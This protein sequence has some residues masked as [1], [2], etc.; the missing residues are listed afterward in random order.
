MG[1]PTHRRVAAQHSQLSATA[2]ST[3]FSELT[4]DLYH[5]C[6]KSASTTASHVSLLAC[7]GPGSLG[8]PISASLPVGP[9]RARLSQICLDGGLSD[10]GLRCCG[11]S[12]AKAQ[13]LIHDT[14]IHL[15]HGAAVQGLSGGLD[16]EL[17]RE[18]QTLK[19]A[20]RCRA[21]RRTRAVPGSAQASPCLPITRA[22]G[23]LPLPQ[24]GSSAASS[25]APD[26]LQQFDS[27]PPAPCNRHAATPHPCVA[28]PR[29]RT[30]RIRCHC[31][32]QCQSS[33]RACCGLQNGQPGLLL[34]KQRRRHRGTIA[35]L[36]LGPNETPLEVYTAC[37]TSQL[38]PSY[39]S[40][41]SGLQW[42]HSAASSGLQAGSSSSTLKRAKSSE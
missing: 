35:A 7:Y 21:Q 19:S 1:L 42:H 28:V 8:A 30:P 6:I 29:Q 39:D 5:R 13:R 41:A 36:R 22:P 26:R 16:K 33:N 24:R 15:I 14:L 2:L 31:C 12:G 17:L 20:G 4:C 23:A 38:S 9:R 18:E 40:S 10:C 27:F 11:L 37:A 3:P 25:V 32:N 34:S